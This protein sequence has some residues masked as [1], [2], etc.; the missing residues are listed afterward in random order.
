MISKLRAISD[1]KKR[2]LGNFFSLSVLQGANYLL[3]LNETPNPAGFR[4][5][6]YA[7]ERG[8]AVIITSTKHVNEYFPDNKSLIKVK[9]CDYLE[10]KKAMESLDNDN[11]L[12]IEIGTNARKLVENH[13]TSREYITH[14]FENIEIL[15]NEKIKD[16]D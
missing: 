8:K 5:L 16:G 13:Y 6:F 1:D 2:L 11:N 10:L 7:M 9:P 15:L 14:L 12:I 3:P 4:M